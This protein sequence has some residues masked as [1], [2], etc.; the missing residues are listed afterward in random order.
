M[1]GGVSRRSPTVATI[2][3]VAAAF[4]GVAVYLAASRATLRLGF[5]LDD[6]WIHQTY[7]RNLALAGEWAFVPG[8][9]SGGSTSPLWTGLLAIGARLR[10][11]P[12][13]WAYLLGTLGLAGAAAA[14]VR[15]FRLQSPDSATWAVGLA[16][17]FALEWHLLWAAASG[18]EVILLVALATVVMFLSRPTVRQPLLVGALVG[19]GIWIR[20]DAVTLGLIPLL[21]IALAGDTPPRSRIGALLRLAGGAALLIGPYLLFNLRTAGTIW[22]STFYA[23]QAE[24][25][26]LLQAPYLVRFLQLAAAPLVGAGILLFPGVVVVV[27]Q[28]VREKR[29]ADLG[30]PAWAL[31]YLAIF[32]ARLPVAYQHGRYQIP[33]LPVILVLGWQGIRRAVPGDAPPI[34]RIVGR[35]WAAATVAVTLAFVL[36]GARAYA[37]DVALIETEMV[38]AARWIVS[39]T[40]P[41]A[42]V[43]AHDIGALGYFGER[44][45]LDMAGLANA[46]VIPFLRDEA[47]LAAYLDAAGAEYLMTFPGWYPSL[48]A[49]GVAVY[50]SFGSF[51]PRQGGENLVVYRWPRPPVVPPEGCMLYS[52]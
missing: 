51:S 20:P 44:A 35:A 22:P 30:P 29:W 34:L 27:V 23:K 40:E 1:T 12:R 13:L 15:V 3:G 11:D 43:A 26:E 14:S 37:Q 38:D 4:A 18:M 39:H 8:T 33:V 47:A 10:W 21:A 7:A 48:T 50:R 49:C 45:V 6:A 41:E 32:A 28:A 2:V 46:E 17:I 31:L 36:I 19:L 16:L 24:Y 5:P 52:P 42:L 25:A 9:A